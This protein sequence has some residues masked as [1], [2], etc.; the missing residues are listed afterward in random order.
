ML[1]E[2][3]LR[4][5]R[6][7][8]DFDF[9]AFLREY[10]QPP[11]RGLRVNTLRCSAEEFERRSPFALAKTPFCAEGY[12]AEEP[13]SGRH[14]WHHAGVFYLQEP[15]AM[16][17][18]EAL[19]PEPGCKVLDLCAAPGG[20]STQIAAKLQGKGLLVCNEIVPSRAK[21]L[22]SNIERCGVR[23]AAVF[24]EK[25]ERLC[26]G[27]PDF[28]DRVLVDAPC[29]GEGMFRRDP[30]AADEW[31]PALPAACTTRQ[32]AIL[33]CAAGALRTGGILV[34]STCTFSPEEDEGVTETFLKR[35]PEF[36]IEEIGR[37]FGRPA[38]PAWADARR[39]II[40]AR[41]IFP[42]DGGEG[43]FVVRFCK[44]AGRMGKIPQVKSARPS[45]KKQN[46]EVLRLFHAF[47]EEQ[48][49]EPL[50]GE[51]YE[52]NGSVF[53][54]PHGLPECTGLNLLR[55]GVF[56]GRAVFGGHSGKGRFEPE[57]ALYMA[58]GKGSFR[59]AADF[60]LESRELADYLAGFEIPAPVGLGKGFAAVLA[61]GFAVGFGK[62]GGGTLKNRCPKGLRNL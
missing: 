28:F 6:A 57:H 7:L 4:R 59:N 50:Y 9:D 38:V 49:D 22:L 1:P 36:E 55:A 53:L 26:A 23:N 3:F 58:A 41:R 27:F 8:P 10:D 29:S 16:S 18:A 20:K 25:P 39:E 46:A 35:H 48:F 17:A 5:M 33:D 43:H 21:I 34:Y 60:S 19:M 62:N 37:T 32:L 13:V 51:P 2:G 61:E 47:Y 52:T 12:I 40:R 30:G 56:A 15:S 54:L 24:C 14:P 42:Q 11:L 45:F 31:S 44:T